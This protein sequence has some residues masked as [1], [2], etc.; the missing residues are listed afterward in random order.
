MKVRN[1][2][3]INMKKNTWKKNKYIMF[4]SVLHFLKKT[5]YTLCK[6]TTKKYFY[7]CLINLIIIM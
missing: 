7:N 3:Y 1:Y 6:A 5:L 2:Y 4:C